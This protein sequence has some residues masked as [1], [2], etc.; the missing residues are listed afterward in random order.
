MSILSPA[1]WLLGYLL[2]SLPFALW[3]TRLVKGIDV[4]DGGSGHVTTTNTIRQAGWIPGAAVF[5]LDFGKGFLAIWL[6]QRAGLSGWSLGLT[7]ALAVA[8]HCWTI[9]AQ[10]RG[11]MGLA[12]MAGVV[13]AV[14]P[15]AFLLAFATLL[16]FVLIIRHAARGSL[17]A[18][19]VAPF[20]LWFAGLRGDV[21]WIMALGAFV[22]AVR[23]T[24]D[25]NR[26][27]R[28]LWLDREKE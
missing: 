20:V 12:V 8:G 25:W 16:F 14:S 9:F 15:L 19:L 26:K 28:E 18:A 4:R 17:I 5:A 11:G 3:I 22:L 27:Y 21:I 2:G 1:C 13:T 10:F 24:I 7:G 6:A 23:F